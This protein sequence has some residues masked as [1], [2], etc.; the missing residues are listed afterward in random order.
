MVLRPHTPAGHR[1]MTTAET[2][3]I[4]TNE[5]HQRQKEQ[6]PSKPTPTLSSLE[7]VADRATAVLLGPV[8]AP[9][10]MLAG[11]GVALPRGRRTGPHIPSL[12]LRQSWPPR[13]EVGPVPAMTGGRGVDVGIAA[14]YLPCKSSQLRAELS[15]KKPVILVPS[16]FRM[17]VFCSSYFLE[18]ILIL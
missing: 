11:V 18:L 7:P 15:E 6:V 17:L 9:G 3:K 13:Q 1:G 4:S 10:H 5:R 16:S 8:T 14:P 12:H 2:Q